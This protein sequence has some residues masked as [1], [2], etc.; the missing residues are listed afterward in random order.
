[1]PFFIKRFFYEFLHYNLNLTSGNVV[2][3]TLDKQ[4]N[5]RLMDDINFTKYKKG[6]QHQ[7]YGGYTTKSPARLTAP[8]SGHWN[9]VIDLGGYL[10][11]LMHQ[12]GFYRNNY[13]ADTRE[14]RWVYC[15]HTPC[16][17]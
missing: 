13:D 15:R 9:L 17:N 10:A 3:V 4:A 12:L 2:E 11:Q 14:R 8:R 6:M 7:Y 16:K 1:M 5:V